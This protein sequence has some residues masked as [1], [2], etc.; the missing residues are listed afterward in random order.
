MAEVL[1]RVTL[2]HIT[3]IDTNRYGVSMWIHNPDLTSVDSVDKKYWK[4]AGDVVSEMDQTEK[5][6]VDSDE[7]AAYK[8]A[9]EDKIDSRSDKLILGGVEWPPASSEYLSMSQTAQINLDV[10]V[11]DM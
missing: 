2:E 5:D 9:K 1:H 8:H 3:G 10:L 6:A 11:Y 4:L 7:L